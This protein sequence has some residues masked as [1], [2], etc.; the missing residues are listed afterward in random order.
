MTVTTSP[1]AKTPARWLLLAAFGA[2]YIVWGSSYVGIH[3]AV[4]SIPPFLMGGVRFGIAGLLMIAWA[5]G[6]GAKRPTRAHWRSASIAG[7]AMFLIN[8]GA[9]MWAATTVP[10]GML[11]LLIA[12]TPMWMVLLDWWRPTVRGRSPG[13]TRPTV[14]VFAGLLIGFFGILMLVNPAQFSEVKPNFAIGVVAV[15]IGTVGWAGGSLYARQADLPESPILCTGMQLLT[16]GVMLLALSVVSGETARF[17]LAEV[18]PESAFAV[19]YLIL[20]G[21]IIG[22]GSYVWL[23]RVSSPARVSTY[24][25][26]NPI[27][28]VLLGWALAGEGLTV[29]TLIAAAVIIGSVMVINTARHHKPAPR[30]A[31]AKT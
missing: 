27:I 15:L 14:M 4:E 31:L 1:R 5:L 11:A 3:F 8:N 29:R 7:L 28:A 9:L 17:T 13:G 21:S 30:P 16:G 22:F 12:A 25:Y 20:F 18:T 6:R 24:A 26:V 2:I 10:S 19:V 23:M